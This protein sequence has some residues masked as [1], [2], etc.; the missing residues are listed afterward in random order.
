MAVTRKHVALFTLYASSVWLWCGIISR[1]KQETPAPP[2][3]GMP[4]APRVPQFPTG[5]PSPEGKVTSKDVQFAELG[6]RF[7]FGAPFVGV[8][9][10]DGRLTVE[11]NKDYLP[12]RMVNGII[13]R[14]A[15]KNRPLWVGPVSEAQFV[16]EARAGVEMIRDCSGAEVW[17]SVR[18]TGSPDLQL[19]SET[20]GQSRLLDKQGALL[21]SGYIAPSQNGRT[22]SRQ[23]N[24]HYEIDCGG[25]HITGDKGVFRITDE[26][27]RL[28]WAGSLPTRPTILVR[29][30]DRYSF[31]GENRVAGGSDRVS[32]ISFAAEKGTV[33]IED[34][35]GNLLATRP[36]DILKTVN[37]VGPGGGPKATSGLSIPRTI[38]PNPTLKTNGVA[39]LTYRDSHGTVIRRS[40]VHRSGNSFGYSG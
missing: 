33:T 24:G 16:L 9:Y 4:S 20:T 25:I 10:A 32:Q 28:I 36:V 38:T 2:T 27:K 1:N 30:G 19:V 26:A 17:S 7:L 29:Q 21:W 37:S 35:S 12:A 13:T 14:P 39:L 15:L 11:E 8:R 3:P 6:D 18:M 34:T 31:I 40:R 5:G 23:T 22:S